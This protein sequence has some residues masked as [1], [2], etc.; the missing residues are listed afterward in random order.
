MSKV[1]CDMPARNILF[2]KIFTKQIQ[3]YPQMVNADDNL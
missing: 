3:K 2:N 1:N